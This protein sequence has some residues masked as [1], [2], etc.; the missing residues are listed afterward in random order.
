MAPSPEEVYQRW[1]FLF[2]KHSVTE[3]SRATMS[4]GSV[5]SAGRLAPEGPGAGQAVC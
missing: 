1:K 4:Y 2:L 5:L 3:S